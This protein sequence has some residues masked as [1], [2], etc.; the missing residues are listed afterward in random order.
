MSTQISIRFG[1]YSRS[2]FYSQPLNTWQKLNLEWNCLNQIYPCKQ[3]AHQITR[4]KSQRDDIYNKT[5]NLIWT[6]S[7][8]TE[9]TSRTRRISMTTRLESRVTCH[10][11]AVYWSC[12]TCARCHWSACV[13]CCH[14]K[15]TMA[16]RR[17]T[18]LLLCVSVLCLG[19]RA[20]VKVLHLGSGPSSQK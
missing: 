7:R 6:I 10:C 19:N 18:G 20:E 12:I 15:V 5:A 13:A 16:V 11:K 4:G 2:Q 8:P 17:L 1:R 14:T 9:L 3:L